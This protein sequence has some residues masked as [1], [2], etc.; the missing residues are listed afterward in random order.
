MGFYT[1]FTPNGEID[2]AKIPRVLKFIIVG[3]AAGLVFKFSIILTMG[4]ILFVNPITIIGLFIVGFFVLVGI[5]N[6]A[7]TRNRRHREVRR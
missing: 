4:V 7:E 3:V 6:A 2:V 5:D 1:M